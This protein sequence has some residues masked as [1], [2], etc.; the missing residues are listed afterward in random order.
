M[1][2]DKDGIFIE[3][4]TE[5]MRQK[6]M[7]GSQLSSA[8]GLTEATISRY[9]NGIR[10]PSAAN[11]VNLS[12]A[13]G[14]SSDYLLGISDLAE[15]KSLSAAFSKASNEDK[16]LIRVILERYGGVYG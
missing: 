6:N 10:Q 8:S 5:R 3:R 7:N 9:I 1:Q 2:T 16:H 12:S 4:L 11:L 14:V 13:L 15:G